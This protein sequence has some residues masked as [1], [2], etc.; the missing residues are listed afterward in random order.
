VKLGKFFFIFY[1]TREEQLG[2]EN[3]KI[4]LPPFTTI[5]SLD[6]GLALKRANSLFKICENILRYHAN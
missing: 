1:L 5:L 6:I 4:F 3:A 2:V